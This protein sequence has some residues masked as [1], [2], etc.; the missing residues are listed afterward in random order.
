MDVLGESRRLSER[1]SRGHFGRI[2]SFHVTTLVAACALVAPIASAQPRSPGIGG[3][4]YGDG[5]GVGV[6]APSGWVFDAESGVAQ[7]LHAVMYPQGSKWADA[8]E[9]M[10]ANVAAVEPGSTLQHFIDGDV[11][12]FR[13]KAPGLVVESRDPLR[14]TGG[15]AA[16]VRYFSGDA[17]GNFEAI[18]Y[19]M[20]GS[21]VAIYVL[22]C[23]KREGFARSLPAF[24]E[25][26]EGSFLVNMAFGK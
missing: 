5:M 6:S 14:I 17:W 19:A 21:N 4:V 7:G 3:I 22:S 18:A 16:Q 13:E 26:V 15:K 10:Y 9:V 24:K 8:I 12:S 11:A 20:Q 1:L 25:M 23:R 2:S